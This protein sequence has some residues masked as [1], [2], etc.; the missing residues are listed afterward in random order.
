MV[1]QER[2]ARLLVDITLAAVEIVAMDK[3]HALCRDYVSRV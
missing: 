3:I 2:A 1:M